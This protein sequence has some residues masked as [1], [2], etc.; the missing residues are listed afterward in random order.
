MS[1]PELTEAQRSRLR[2]LDGFDLG[3]AEQAREKHTGRTFERA[4]LL[5][6]DYSGATVVLR[7]TDTGR[8]AL[9]GTEDA[10]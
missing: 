4:G 7:L 5:A 2:G 9:R 1:T 3:R 6:R 10:S 8:A